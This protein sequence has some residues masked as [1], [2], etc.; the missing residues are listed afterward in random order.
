MIGEISAAPISRT[1]EAIHTAVEAG[2]KGSGHGQLSDEDTAK[3]IAE[4]GVGWR[5]RPRGSP[6]FS[7]AHC[8]AARCCWSAV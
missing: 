2:R 1:P 6:V 5:R 4:K 3:F 7:H 8:R